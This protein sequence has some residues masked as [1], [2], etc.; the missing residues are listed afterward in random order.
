ML[1][2]TGKMFAKKYEAAK[3]EKDD[4]QAQIA[5]LKDMLAAMDTSAPTAGV[6]QQFIT[7]NITD[8]H[9]DYITHALAESCV[10]DVAPSKGIWMMVEKMYFD[11]DHP[12][13]H[14][15]HLKNRDMVEWIKDS[16]T[17]FATLVTAAEAM[18]EN[19]R[20][21]LRT[22][23]V[24]PFRMGHLEIENEG[25]KLEVFPLESEAPSTSPEQTRDQES[26]EGKSLSLETSR[27]LNNPMD[28]KMIA[29]I[30]A[31][32]H[33]ALYQRKNTGR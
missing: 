12:E 32:V 4:L 21:F 14:T 23:V 13:N 8:F 11:K 30:K 9:V 6:S 7:N 29:K 22:N 5:K 16:T 2:A 17:Q 25:E 1:R 20:K 31:Q 33:G 19:A 24:V 3:V 27:T 28:D 10:F 15:V 18:A 26:N